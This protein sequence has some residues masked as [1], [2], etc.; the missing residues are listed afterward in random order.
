VASLL[1]L[2]DLGRDPPPREALVARGVVEVYRAR[3]VGDYYGNFSPGV[4]FWGRG[5]SSGGLEP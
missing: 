1:G 4:A 3:R 5:V 2:A